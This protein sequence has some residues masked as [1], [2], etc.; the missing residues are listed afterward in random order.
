MYGCE[1]LSYG[2]VKGLRV[3]FPLAYSARALNVI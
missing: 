3:K 2:A 1:D